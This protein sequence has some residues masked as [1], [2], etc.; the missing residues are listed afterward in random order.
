M[1]SG[2]AVALSGGRGVSVG[3]WA[4]LAPAVNAKAT[5]AMERMGF[6]TDP[7]ISHVKERVAP[8]LVATILLRAK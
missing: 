5:A 3:C 7:R 1:D 4:K 8:R 6:M 2:A